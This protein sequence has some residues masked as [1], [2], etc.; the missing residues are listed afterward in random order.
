MGTRLW[1]APALLALSR[2]AAMRE[3]PHGFAHPK[4]EHGSRTPQ[5]RTVHPTTDRSQSGKNDLSATELYIV[6]PGFQLRRHARESGHPETLAEDWIPACAG[7]TSDVYV[8]N[9]SG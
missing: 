9:V 1:S 7:M 6:T 8:C 5:A 2:R 4:R 3:A